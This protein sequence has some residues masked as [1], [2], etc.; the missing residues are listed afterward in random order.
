MSHVYRPVGWNTFKRRYD[1]WLW[2]AIAG[3]VA[4]YVGLSLAL[5]KGLTAE[6]LVI[7]ATALAAFTLLHLVLCTGPLARLDARFLPLLYNR[8][9]MGVS[10]FALALV[11]GAFAFVQ[12]HALGDTDPLVSLLSTPW[13]GGA[14]GAPFQLFGAL[15][16]AILFLMAATSHDFWLANLT[17]PVWKA[18]H[19]GV[20]A[21]Y[22][23]IVAHV[24]FGALQDQRAPL[25]ALGTAAGAVLVVALHLAAAARERALDGAGASTAAASTVAAS[26]VAAEVDGGEVATIPDGRARIVRVGGERVALFRDGERV[27][28]L[29]NVCQHQNGPLGEGCIRDG[30]VTCPWHGYQYRPDDGCSPPPFT[31]RVPTFETRVADGRVWIAAR[32]R[33]APRRAATQEHA[34]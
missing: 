32:P 25:L 17:A 15:A 10:M 16:L 2:G 14:A 13:V 4:L 7:R 9:H 30:L 18:L 31:E 6:T 29:S 3:F 24:A 28:A 23:L 33:P 11:H 21:A 20:Y 12:F 19:M 8:R 22:A 26:T 27:F 1:L 5:D 34:P